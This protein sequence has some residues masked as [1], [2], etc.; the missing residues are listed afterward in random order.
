MIRR[1]SIEPH[2]NHERWLVSY[3]DFITLLF[4]FFVVMY[5]VSQV[6]ENKYRVLSDTLA[7]AFEGADKAKSDIETSLP[8]DEE[9]LAKNEAEQPARIADVK[10]LARELSK[11]LTAKINVGEISISA[12]ESWV[13]IQLSSNVLFASGS[14]IPGRTAKNLFAEISTL[15]SPYDNAIEVSGHTDNKSINTEKFR[16]NWELSAARAVSVVSLL[17]QGGVSPERLSAVGF[18]EHRPIEDNGSAAGRAKN[19]RVVLT[20]AQHPVERPVVGQTQ[21]ME[22]LSSTSATE[23]ETNASED[24]PNLNNPPIH[25]IKLDNGGLLFTSDPDLPR[26][27]P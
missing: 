1:T 15:L 14:A 9:A 8:L 16:N 7:E 22:D 3:A 26:N 20:I 12:T 18:G 17:S 19:R 6:N 27:Q 23:G 11:A 10:E 2:L 21:V 24:S 25:P 13:E 4:A 5:S